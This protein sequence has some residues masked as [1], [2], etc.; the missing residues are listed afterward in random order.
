M[1]S[2]TLSG[3]SRVFLPAT[4]SLPLT[5][6]PFIRWEIS[7]QH[8]AAGGFGQ[9]GHELNAIGYLEMRQALPAK[10][11][12]FRFTGPLLHTRAKHHTC[13]RHLS[14]ARMSTRKNIG[15]FNRRVL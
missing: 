14:K 13:R 5:R 7:V 9:S 3:R 6:C 8:L 10:L 12:N 4:V 15:G 1:Q 11:N 2:A